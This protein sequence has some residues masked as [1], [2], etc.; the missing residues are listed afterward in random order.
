MTPRK[1][2]REKGSRRK[3]ERESE[4]EKSRRAESKQQNAKKCFFDFNPFE[5]FHSSFSFSLFFRY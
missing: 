5:I 3:Q 1:A 2:C 4:S